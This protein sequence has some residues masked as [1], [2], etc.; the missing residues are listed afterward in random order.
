M[1]MPAAAIARRMPAIVSGYGDS[2][3]GGGDGG[4]GGTEGGGGGAGGG[5]DDGGGGGNRGGDGGIGGGL[6]LGDGR[7]GGDGGGGWLGFGACHQLVFSC[8]AASA[9]S[10][11]TERI[12]TQIITARGAMSTEH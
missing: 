5:G 1:Q 3:L 11:E 7:G 12:R 10:R 2:F 4:G 6:G 9:A 8:G